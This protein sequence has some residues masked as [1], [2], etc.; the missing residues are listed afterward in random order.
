LVV[1]AAV[2]GCLI[3]IGVNTNDAGADSKDPP[4]AR[5]TSALSLNENASLHVVHASGSTLYEEGRGSG[6]LAGT[7]RAWLVIGAT[8]TGHFVFTTHH[9]EITGRGS[10]QPSQG[11][12]PYESFSGSASITGGTGRYRH[13]HGRLGFY[14]ALNRKTDAVQFQTRG[15]LS[16]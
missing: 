4:H 15:T 1:L 2:L 16:Y 10:A 11:A 3:W 7:M 8:Y 6:S 14:G 12:Y 9:G 5:A 13:A